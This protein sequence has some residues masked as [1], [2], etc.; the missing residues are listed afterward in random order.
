M[1]GI[2]SGVTTTGANWSFG[3]G[4]HIGVGKPHHSV[5]SKLSGFIE[6]MLLA[7]RM[8]TP[9]PLQVRT[10]RTRAKMGSSPQ[11]YNF[12]PVLI[13]RCEVIAHSFMNA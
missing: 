1:Q 6:L 7:V 11:P 12:F 2:S 13:E 10:Y 8:E 5:Q 3:S 4:P 9:D